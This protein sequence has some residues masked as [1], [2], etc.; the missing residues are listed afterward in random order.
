M[1]G[2]P[3]DTVDFPL[4]GISSCNNATSAVARCACSC[5]HVEVRMDR[6]GTHIQQLRR[7]VSAA[8][9]D[10]VVRA[11]LHT[12]GN[13]QHDLRSD[14]AAGA[15]IA[16]RADDGDDRARDTIGLRRAAADDGVCGRSEQQRGC[17][18]GCK[19]L[20]GNTLWRQHR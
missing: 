18:E 17:D 9:D 3:T 12:V 4:S 5:L 11:G 14:Q 8:I 10:L 15:E 20:H 7:T 2:A 1:V 6:D 16:T 13:R 19:L